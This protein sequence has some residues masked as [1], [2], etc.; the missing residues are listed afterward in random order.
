MDG[1][2]LRPGLC[3]HPCAAVFLIHRTVLLRS[4]LTFSFLV[5]TNTEYHPNTPQNMSPLSPVDIP[6]T[7]TLE[8]VIRYG[9]DQ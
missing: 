8:K 9:G 4:L 7:P 6:A 5:K 2:C 1:A 3:T